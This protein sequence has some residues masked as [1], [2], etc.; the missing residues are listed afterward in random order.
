[1]IIIEKSYSYSSG[2]MIDKLIEKLDNSRI[3]DYE[4]VEKIPLD[5]VSIVPDSEDI[6]IYIPESLDYVQY[7]IDDYLRKNERFVRTSVNSINKNMLLM[8]LSSPLQFNQ[9]YKLIEHIIS[10]EG[11]CSI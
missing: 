4:V 5:T 3:E 2:K 10:E 6:T 11:F 7:E 1:M 9:I 8:K